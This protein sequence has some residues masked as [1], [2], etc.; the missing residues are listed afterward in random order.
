MLLTWKV[1]HL[2]IPFRC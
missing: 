2:V 1:T